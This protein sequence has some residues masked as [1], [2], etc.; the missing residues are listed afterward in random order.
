M[1]LTQSDVIDC[2][3]FCNSQIVYL[4]RNLA[5]LNEE[6]EYY[7]CEKELKQYLNARK[8][9]TAVLV[10][11]LPC[12]CEDDSSFAVIGEA[13]GVQLQILL[14]SGYL[15]VEWGW[16]KLNKN[17][18]HKLWSD[19]V[20]KYKDYFSGCHINMLPEVN[21][22]FSLEMETIGFN[23]GNTYFF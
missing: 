20:S 19:F 21:D 5:T 23:F 14:L 10:N 4:E 22:R 18:V 8:I 9:I 12:K 7:E 3:Q 11:N 2:L 16:R 15:N 13:H 17:V 1:N 6:D